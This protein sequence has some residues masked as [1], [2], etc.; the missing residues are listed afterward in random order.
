MNI[1]SIFVGAWGWK[2]LGFA[3]G[4]LPVLILWP[5]WWCKVFSPFKEKKKYL[6]QY[7]ML[8]PC[9][10]LYVKSIK[11]L[12]TAFGNFSITFHTNR[13]KLIPRTFE[14]HNQNARCDLVNN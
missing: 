7:W 10:T 8:L 1:Y 14:N 5:F 9:T 6:N 13:F 11:G 2:G 4:F 3:W 12:M